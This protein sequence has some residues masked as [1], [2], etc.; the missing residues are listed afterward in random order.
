M[1][2]E[3]A[4]NQG[5]TITGN[6]SFIPGCHNDDQGKWVDLA[7][8]VRETG[9]DRSTI[10]KRIKSGK[11]KGEKAGHRWHMRLKDYQ[12]LVETY[13]YGKLQTRT[14]IWWTDE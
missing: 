13:R 10:I 1:N 11:L 3:S 2:W 4:Y 6:P 14:G 7:R 5:L 8:V 12:K 9:I